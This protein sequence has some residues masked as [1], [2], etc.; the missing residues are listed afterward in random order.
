MIRSAKKF[1]LIGTH[2]CHAFEALKPWTAMLANAIELHRDTLSF[3]L[4]H[5]DHMVHN[6]LQLHKFKA[7]RIFFITRTTLS[8]L[9]LIADL[10]RLVTLRIDLQHCLRCFTLWHQNP[11]T[12]IREYAR[13]FGEV[14]GNLM[15]TA[16]TGPGQSNFS[17]LSTGYRVA[18]ISHP[19]GPIEPR[20]DRCPEN[21]G[22]CDCS[23]GFEISD[24]YIFRRLDTWAT[25]I[26]VVEIKDRFPESDILYLSPPGH[27]SHQ[28]NGCGD[29]RQ[30]P[31]IRHFI[32]FAA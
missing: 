2:S 10:P 6:N 23:H 25:R 16:A 13:I 3:L 26:M 12:G 9:G 27:L 14:A 5:F 29:Q 7:A 19:T 32:S 4:I 20:I 22:S 24:A 18:S 11:F 1:W 28:D 30:N 15:T 31:R 8:C 17:F 21:A